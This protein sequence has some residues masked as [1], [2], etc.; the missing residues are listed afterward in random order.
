MLPVATRG[1]EGSTE[2][3][4]I[5]WTT[6]ASMLV[7]VA[8]AHT[9]HRSHWPKLRRKEKP[10]QPTCL[11]PSQLT[12]Q[13][14]K[15]KNKNVFRVF[16]FFADSTREPTLFS[17]FRIRLTSPFYGGAPRP[18][19]LTHTLPTNQ[20]SPTRMSPGTHPPLG[21]SRATERE[22]QVPPYLIN[23]YYSLN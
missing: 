2:S 13:K 9:H 17:P 8:H 7:R 11:S 10:W 5:P 21:A 18:H 15:T 1:R 23:L 4:M 12:N 22:V 16:F 3:M 14:P 6:C 20:P 19:T